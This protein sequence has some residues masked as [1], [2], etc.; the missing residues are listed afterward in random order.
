MNN[1][2]AS[3]ILPE[4][5]PHL[6]RLHLNGNPISRLAVPQGM[7]IDNLRIS[8]FSKS[9]IAFYDLETSANA[10]L[11]ILRLGDSGLT[12]SWS[13]G[14]LQSSADLLGNWEDVEIGESPLHVE[15]VESS[16]FFRLRP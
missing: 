9:D 13:G 5:M 7:N 8:G 4:G 3:L 10:T 1:N 16:K 15:A 11:A 14:R 12:I 2:L 6:R